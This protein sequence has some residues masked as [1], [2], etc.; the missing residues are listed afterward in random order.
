MLEA[1]ARRGHARAIVG[2]GGERAAGKAQRHEPRQLR[3]PGAS[4]A[5]LRRL[6][7]CGCVR[8]RL[9][10]EGKRDQRRR[11]GAPVLFKQIVEHN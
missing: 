9:C 7:F 4:D 5:P 10:L 11:S 3:E 1:R 8:P 6:A 2:C